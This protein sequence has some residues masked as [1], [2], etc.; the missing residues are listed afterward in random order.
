MVSFKTKNTRIKMSKI[1]AAS[2]ENLTSLLFSPLFPKYFS[3]FP[4][5]FGVNCGSYLKDT[6]Q[7]G[8]WPGFSK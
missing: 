3:L 1:C 7:P 6:R 4:F 2:E 8:S 5:S